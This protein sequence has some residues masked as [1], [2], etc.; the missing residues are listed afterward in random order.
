MTHVHYTVLRIADT[1]CTV[2]LPL[3]GNVVFNQST[4]QSSNYGEN[5]FSF[6]SSL[7]VDG[8]AGQQFYNK[9]YTCS[10]T[11]RIP[12]PAFWAVTLDARYNIYRFRIHNRRCNG[13]CKLT[14]IFFLLSRIC[15]T[16][17]R[18]YL[19]KAHL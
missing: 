16:G 15:W 5:G 9:P 12:H 14:V 1:T 2:V 3:A 18:V 10:H 4:T 6:V 8:R 13:E 11:E 17:L 7:A 19:H